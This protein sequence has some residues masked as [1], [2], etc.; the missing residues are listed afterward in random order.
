VVVV[1]VWSDCEVVGLASIS[2][3]DEFV[4]LNVLADV[5]LSRLG[6]VGAPLFEIWFF[7]S[8]QFCVPTVLVFSKFV[9]VLSLAW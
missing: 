9:V 1:F 8:F 5:R 7:P 3:S 4:W 6:V 2:S